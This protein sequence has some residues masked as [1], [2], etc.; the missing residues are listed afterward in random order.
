MYSSCENQKHNFFHLKIL[1]QQNLMPTYEIIALK[2]YY[3]LK[4]ECHS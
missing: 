4:I 1:S 2:K 3:F